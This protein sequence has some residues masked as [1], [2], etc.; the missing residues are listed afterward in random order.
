MAHDKC[1]K[2]YE[3]I[4]KNDQDGREPRAKRLARGQR[5]IG[6]GQG[7]V[8]VGPQYRFV[9]MVKNVRLNTLTL[10]SIHIHHDGAIG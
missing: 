8:L 9:F 3:F 1:E 7:L 4:M 2:T 6:G 5:I 10:E